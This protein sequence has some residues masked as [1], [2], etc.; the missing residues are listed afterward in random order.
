MGTEEAENILADSTA[1]RSATGDTGSSTAHSLPDRIAAAKFAGA[2][3]RAG[4]GLAG[5]RTMK[6][7]PGHP[8]GLRVGNYR[9]L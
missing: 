1:P 4:C 3:R 8:T 5:V 6:I 2:S 9:D 7:Q